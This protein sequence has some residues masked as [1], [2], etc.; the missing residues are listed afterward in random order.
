MTTSKRPR[1]LRGDSTS[2]TTN[3]VSRPRCWAPARAT[4]SIPSEVDAYYLVT[5]LAQQQCQE[6][7]AGAHVEDAQGRRRWHQPL[8]HFHPRLPLDGGLQ[9]RPQ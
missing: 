9:S 8:E 7:G 6:P 5:D 3:V 1:S 2:P 4:E